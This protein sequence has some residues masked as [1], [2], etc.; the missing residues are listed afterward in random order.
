MK[1]LLIFSLTFFALNQAKAQTFKIVSSS[2]KE[3]IVEVEFQNQN[4]QSK[5]LNGEQF[6]DFSSLNAPLT[7][8]A[9]APAM[10]MY[11]T[12]IQLPAKGNPTVEVVG[13]E[14][15]DYLFTKVLPSKGSLKRNVAP[16]SVPY[17]FGAV[18]QSNQF[19]PGTLGELED[20]F[21][22][23][24]ARG[25]VL[26][27]S[28]FQFNPSTSTVQYHT[29]M[30]FRIRY[31][32]TS[33]GM[34]EL[35]ETVAD[36]AM[37]KLQQRTFLNHS[38][39]KY[40]ILEEQGDLLVI[41]T[42]ALT[43]EIQP[44]VNWKN[45]KGIKTTVV[46]TATTGTTD[47][48]IKAY[49]T[50]AFQSNPNLVYVLLVG[51]HADVPSHTYGNSGGEELWSDSYYGQ[52]TGGATDF[53]PEL[54]I[55][56]FS[57][58]ASQITTQVDRTLEYEKN[59]A[60]GDW[61]E[62]AIGLGSDEGDGIGDDSE[63]D[64]QHLRN[65]RSVLMNYGYSS[66]SEFYD[67]NHGGEDASGNPNSSIIL[68]VVNAG[69]GL[70][71]YTGHGD[72]N[73]CVTGNFS[74]T[75]VNQA[76]NNGFYPFV[77]SVACNNGTFTTG[78]CI[79]EV[80]MSSTNNNAPAGAIAAAG[81]SILM[82]WAEP[83]Q[84]QDE[85]AEIIAENYPSNKKESLGGLFYNSQCS[86]LE[87][88]PGSGGKEVMQTWVLFGDPS[89]VFRNKQTMP[90][91]ISHTQ[92]VNN[93]ATSILVN[94]DVE[95]CMIAVSQNNVLLGTAMSSGGGATVNFPAL[96]TN[97][98][99]LVTV[100]KQNHI[101]YQDAVQVGNG[102]VGLNENLDLFTVYPV[103]TADQLTVQTNSS[104]L[105]T[106]ELLDMNGVVVASIKASNNGT[107][108]ISVGHLA[109]GNYVMKLSG[110]GITSRKLVQIIK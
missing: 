47:V 78:T 81:S 73:V 107:T 54:F 87:D 51:D 45:Q 40:T 96:V 98:P 4:W 70:F 19:Y 14:Y 15:V 80:W 77:I 83:M 89:A 71:N 85:M 49:L 52:L 48:E 61:M 9:G 21:L 30:T 20:P 42:D 110:N 82:N 7:N 65:I 79:S 16:S 88:Y 95:D 99:I 27:V 53:Y 28:P 55:G 6:V 103:P 72:Q 76:T 37:Q 5:E 11:H 13:D 22:W 97:D 43:D 39:E 10:P 24:S 2:P 36:P 59:P 62:K 60:A 31:N 25:I 68:P 63:P 93:G 74:S 41:T 104:S 109:A 56:R 67:G 12:T 108:N 44:L 34:N 17:S 29:K 84:T 106:I 32:E 102:P 57:G 69:V 94:C 90:I 26:T 91:V 58:S 18:Y 92:N 8:E 64:W 1:K 46:T 50:T 86:M 33:T 101:S 105:E 3:M 38:A 35:S 23:R 100:T 75:N 66:V